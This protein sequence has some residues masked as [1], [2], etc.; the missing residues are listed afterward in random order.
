MFKTL[1]LLLLAF[2][3]MLEP[4]AVLARSRSA[5]DVNTEVAGL[6]LFRRSPKRGRPNYVAY[7]GNSR[8]KA[9][10][11]GAIRRWKL[12]RKAIKKRRARGVPS[13]RVGAPTR[14]LKK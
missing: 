6:S 9:K 5:A 10:K 13:V 11:L 2:V 14:V 12:H 8:H 1:L 3:M 7:H 4:D